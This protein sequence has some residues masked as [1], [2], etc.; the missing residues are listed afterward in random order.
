MVKPQQ[1][2]LTSLDAS[3][4]SIPFQY[5]KVVCYQLFYQEQK[6][7]FG[8]LYPFLTQEQINLKIK[9]KWKHL[10]ADKKKKYSKVVL[11]VTPLKK[12]AQDRKLT[13]S[14]PKY[15]S[16]KKKGSFMDNSEVSPLLSTSSSPV[17]S[18]QE[19]VQHW[20]NDPKHG[21]LE[22]GKK[23]ETTQYA[24]NYGV[25]EII[26]DTPIKPTGILKNKSFRYPV[27]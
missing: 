22:N 11:C 7:R 26:E 5:Q 20:L 10:E 13:I 23:Y 3:T 27:I 21:V 8:L 1:S 19:K 16:A 2:S 4:L 24:L 9:E 17:I 12:S 18:S 25:P 14:T 15:S 6:A